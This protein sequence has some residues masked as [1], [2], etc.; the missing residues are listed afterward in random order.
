MSCDCINHVNGLLSEQNTQLVAT[1]FG[2]PRKVVVETVKIDSKKRGRPPAM[3]ASYCP[4]CGEEYAK[5][6]G[7]S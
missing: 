7:R 2:E 4:F 1:I 5:A 6:E 3:L